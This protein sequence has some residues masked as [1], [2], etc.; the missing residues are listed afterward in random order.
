MH[1]RTA[2]I[3]R[4]GR[5]YEYIQLVES[6]R[7]PS[8]GMPAH[9]VVG[10]LGKLSPVEVENLRL[11]LSAAR[12]GKRVVLAPSGALTSPPH[13]R[14]VANLRYLDVAV[15]WELLCQCGLE[16]LLK[17]ALPA[18][19]AEMP[20]HLAVAALAIQR[21]VDAGSKLYATR[22]VPRTALPELLG[23]APAAFNNTRVHR[24][25][26]ELDCA[27]PAIM[28][29][30]PRCY[31][32]QEGAFGALFLDVTDTWFVGH[33]PS[34]AE[35]AKTKEGRM[36]WKV[37]I[38]LLCNQQGYPL[39]WE[40]V[41]GRMSDSESMSAMMRSVSGLPWTAEVPLVMD[42]AMGKTALIRQMLQTE[43]RFVT[44]LT[45]TE[46]S[47]Y[48]QAIP[49]APFQQLPSSWWEQDFDEQ[50]TCA[51]T[52]AQ[53]AGLTKVDE[54]LFVLDLG[55]IEVA[56]DEGADVEGPAESAGLVQAMQ[57]CRRMQELVAGGQFTS[58]AAAGRS[59]G[60]RE[61]VS[62][63]YR[64][65]RGLHE[66]IQQ[67]VLLGRADGCSLTALLALA[68]R[69]DAEEQRREF[70]RLLQ[71]AGSSPE[72]RPCGHEAAPAEALPSISLRAAVYFNPEQFVEQRNRAHQL[73]QEVDDFVRSLNGKL[74]RPESRQQP[75]NIRVLVDRKLHRLE[76]VEAFG[77][78]VFETEI[79]GRK[80]YQLDLQLDQTDWLRRRR[81]DGFTLLVAHPRL[82]HTAI[83]L[84]RLYRAKDAVEKDFQ[85]IKSLIELRPVRHRNDGK[86]RAH[87]SV[88]MLSLV[89]ERTLENK[90]RG[91]F[92]P[93]MALEL[94]EPCRLNQY[95][96]A[97]GQAIYGLT[98]LSPE[99]MRI[100]RRLGLTQLADET[101]VADRIKPR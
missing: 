39:R 9:R 99:Q 54:K 56:V 53:T 41:R 44:A 7:R 46:F 17:E 96:T 87:V 65:L 37:G 80:R 11:A 2:R 18:G 45:E 75:E 19:E 66:Q 24:V 49:Y 69:R 35:R 25:L 42:R 26:D 85:A 101:A 30:L 78:R 97:R 92:S 43:L 90:L 28:A 31:E 64:R 58:H 10:N 34:M 29:R 84:C 21:C 70:E 60:L 68:G 33:G 63:K 51:A 79:A 50:V 23:F 74:A 81:Y 94:L 83:E 95:G 15:L 89:L 36:E 93:Q 86:V 16:G 82:P 55:T 76:L 59:L 62:K 5:T 100:L 91:S 98:Q 8:D 71:T 12:E 13:P 57:L 20:L 22:W 67:D 27:T 1:L 48:S 3:R 73:L 38:V 14:P 77:V 72:Q 88:C 47:R 6:F 32:E 61:S 52:C 40:V 4:Q